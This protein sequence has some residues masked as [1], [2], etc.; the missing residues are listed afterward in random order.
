MLIWEENTYFFY[1]LYIKQITYWSELILFCKIGK[2]WVINLEMIRFLVLTDNINNM[3]DIEIIEF[4]RWLLPCMQDKPY[5]FSNVHQ[6]TCH[7]TSVCMEDT[8]TF[9]HSASLCSMINKCQNQAD[10][11]HI[12]SKSMNQSLTV[13]VHCIFALNQAMR[14]YPYRS[15]LLIA[16]FIPQT[17]V[18][19]KDFITWWFHTKVQF[20]K[21]Q[22]LISFLPFQRVW[23]IFPMLK[24]VLP[25]A[26]WSLEILEV[27]SLIEGYLRLF[28][29]DVNFDKMWVP[30][31]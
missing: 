2:G 23:V 17:C 16:L 12:P 13:T 26:Y 25:C 5:W 3:I 10:C 8:W 22:L 28:L 18:F 1:F 24:W 14:S 19:S 9:P 15:V 29:C 6:C 27:V 30:I 20:V 11:F 7:G 31:F 21:Y 4:K